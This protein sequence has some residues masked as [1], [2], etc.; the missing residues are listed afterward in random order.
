[1]PDDAIDA[2]VLDRHVFRWWGD[3]G[4]ALGKLR[5]GKSPPIAMHDLRIA[6]I[7]ALDRRVPLLAR[8][9]EQ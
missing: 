8:G 6:G 7:Q 5:I 1:M 2:L 3:R 9:L 4:R